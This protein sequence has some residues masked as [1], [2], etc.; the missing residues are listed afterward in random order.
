LQRGNCA[1]WIWRERA[2]R[3]AS[4]SAENAGTKRSSAS[5]AGMAMAMA[6]LEGFLHMYVY[7]YVYTYRCMYVCVYVCVFIP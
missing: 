4:F 2:K 6:M 7:M 1:V 5:D 3:T